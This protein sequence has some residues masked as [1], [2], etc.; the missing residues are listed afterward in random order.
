MT[1]LLQINDIYVTVDYKFSKIPLSTSTN[2]AIL[3]QSSS[4]VWF[5]LHVPFRGQQHPKYR[6]I[7]CFVNSRF[8]CKVR[9]YQTHKQKSSEDRSG[10]KREDTILRAT[11]KH[12]YFGNQN[13]YSDK[14]FFF[15][16]WLILS[17]PPPPNTDHSSSNSLYVSFLFC[18]HVSG[19]PTKI[20]FQ[21]SRVSMPHATRL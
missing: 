17:P 18:V 3:V 12:L 11:F 20:G 13:T 2:F 16:Q 8:F 5:D 7:I 14:L 1:N 6:P 10:D 19:I 4:V 9:F 15:S 21:K